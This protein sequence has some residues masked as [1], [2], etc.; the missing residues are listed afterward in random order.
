M[1]LLQGNP[2]EAFIDGKLLVFSHKD[3]PG[4]IARIGNVL[5]EE[6]VNIAQMAVGRVAAGG[7]ALGVLNLDSNPSEAALA[8]LVE[9]GNVFVTKLIE[10]PAAGVLPEW[11][12]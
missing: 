3:V 10:L 6:S 1:V 11:L 4:I 8:K 5:A 12:A 2:I 9:D 7:Q